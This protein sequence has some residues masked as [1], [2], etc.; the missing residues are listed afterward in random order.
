MPGIWPNAGLRAYR[1]GDSITINTNWTDNGT[2]VDGRTTP[3]A[4]LSICAQVIGDLEMGPSALPYGIL[5][6]AVLAKNGW[7]HLAF[8]GNNGK[9]HEY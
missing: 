7:E 8:R 5:S 1:D 9:C 3:D 4:A 2:T 6:I